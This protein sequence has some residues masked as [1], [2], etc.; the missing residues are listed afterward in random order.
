LLGVVCL[1]IIEGI[2]RADKASGNIA[3]SNVYVVVNDK[4]LVVIDTGTPGNAKKIVE[5]IQEIGHQPQ[6]VTISVLTHSH[7]DHTGSLKELKDLT[8][9]KVAASEEDADYISRKKPYPKPKNLLMRAAPLLLKAQPVEVDLVLKDGDRLGNL[10]VAHTPGHTP[11][12]IMLYDAERKAL[13]SGDSLRLEHGKVSGGQ[14]SWDAA[15]ERLSIEKVSGLDFDVLLPG[16][17]D[18]LKGNASNL[19]KE[20]LRS[21]R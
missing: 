17:G 11:G 4:G 5:Y 8:G 10:V 18:C 9:A 7:L 21:L 19:V 6:E 15:K 1:E 13:F 2:F 20:Y 14:Y 12:S 3:H 16:H